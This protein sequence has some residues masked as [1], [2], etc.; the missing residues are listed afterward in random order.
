MRIAILP[1]ML[2]ML[3]FL[4]TG[5][6]SSTDPSDPD[7]NQSVA[8]IGSSYS[9]NVYGLDAFG[10]TGSSILNQ[11]KFVVTGTNESYRGEDGL[12]TLLHSAKN[13]VLY[14]KFMPEG[15]LLLYYSPFGLPF[16]PFMGAA[17][18]RFPFSGG[19]TGLEVLLD[20]TYLNASQTEE[21]LL[22]KREATYL[23][24]ET[25][26]LN[27]E[28]FSTIKVEE[29]LE[30]MLF[31]EGEPESAHITELVYWYA[32]AIGYFVQID[33]RTYYGNP[34]DPPLWSSYRDKLVDY[35]LK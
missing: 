2:L 11:G 6:E 7:D 21:R 32:P 16:G 9:F 4:A 26:T 12:V 24:E 35:E 28:Q 23:G 10:N 15:D 17:W 1:S 30:Q 13:R 25:L 3:A 20:S 33:S 18:V 22:V 31:S 5:C 34:D 8:G 14:L 19:T 29:R 27:G